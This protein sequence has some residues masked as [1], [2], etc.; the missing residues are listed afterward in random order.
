MTRF[1]TSRYAAVIFAVFLVILLGAEAS[2]LLP[3]G[4]MIRALA[5]R[6]WIACSALILVSVLIHAVIPFFRRGFWSSPDLCWYLAAF[7]V[8]VALVL[9]DVNGYGYTQ[10][11]DEGLQQVTSG[12]D[13]MSGRR[14]LGLFSVGFLGYPARQYLL[15]AMPSRIFG[16][17]LVTLRVGFGGFYLLG[18]LSFLS[19]AWGYLEARKSWRPMLL[20]SLAGMLVALGSY[21]LLFARLFE[22]TTVPLSLMLLFLSGLLLFLS[23]P[24]PLSGVWFLWALGLMPYS[25]TP[26]LAAWGLGMAVL[27]CL[28]SS[29]PKRRRI[30]LLAGLAYGAV[31][32]AVALAVQVRGNLLPSRLL[33]AGLAG[34]HA[35]GL[36]GGGPAAWA[37]RLLN[38]LHST[39]GIEESLVPA[40]LAL[41]ILFILFHSLRRRDYRVLALCLWAAVT[42]VLSLAL[43]GYW[44][45]VPEFDIQRAMVILPPLSLALMMYAAAHSEAL[46]AE[47][48]EA[49]L[50]GLILSAAVFMLLN[51]AYLPL[52]RRVPRA[53]FPFEATDREEAAMFFVRGAAPGARVVYV[54]PPLSFRLDETLAYFSPGTR[55]VSAAPPEGEHVEGSYVIS[56]AGL[57][58]FV[59]EDPNAR[60]ADHPVRF[61]HPRPYLRISPE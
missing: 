13:L 18:Y 29:G 61:L 2:C 45:R 20:A 39:F 50:R 3:G 6:A 43:K 26:S 30:P 35:S 24:G 60:L 47:K 34:D 33:A 25:Y 40:P 10:I 4:G 49:A 46:P 32:L 52:I 1:E 22:Q 37:S 27:A 19:C 11:N 41:G 28:A 55:V 12:L 31:T 14:D 59:S 21:P 17:G 53:Y 8:P 16:R 5:A 48:G 38:G 7:L 36:S 9:F 15:A 44:Q 57:D 42:V 54:E 56:Y 23:R 58:P 51:A